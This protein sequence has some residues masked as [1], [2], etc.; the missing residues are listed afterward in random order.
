MGKDKKDVRRERGEK[1]FS[2]LE[3]IISVFVLT[4][5]LLGAMGAYAFI[6]RDN[7]TQVYRTL[8][9]KKCQEKME[10][11]LA[12]SISSLPSQNNTTFSVDF[13]EG[14]PPQNIGRVYVT[15]VSYPPGTGLLYEIRVEILYNGDQNH[16]PINVSII[17]RKAKL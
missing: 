3:V 16:P 6:I 13:L 10:T 1:G 9:Y 11:L 8:A 7:K 4:V 15:D 12:M 2:L 17:A 14:L 5:I